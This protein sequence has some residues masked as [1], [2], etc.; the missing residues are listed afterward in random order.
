VAALAALTIVLTGCGSTAAPAGSSAASSSAASAPAGSA[1]S[2]SAS[3]A[4]AW[5]RASEGTALSMIAE[6]TLNSQ[7]L[8]SLLPD[9]TA[10]TGI[11]VQLE[12]APYDSVV[13]KL[14]L[15]ATT[16][17]GGYDIVS[18]PYEF[19]GAFA[20]KGWI[21]P[22]DD[23]LADTSSFGPGFD[24]SAIIPAL[25]TASSVWRDK[26]YGMPSNSAVMMMFY[27]KDLFENA[28]EQAAFRA[29]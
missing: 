18:L 5:S 29:K 12:Q 16:K 25:W 19:L 3:G 6:A 23:R 27:R 13:Q 22:I 7:V 8:E 17:Q 24:P 26:T 28:A 4:A 2:P 1:G 20:E 10:K 15:D 14:T 9:F 21:S 11:D